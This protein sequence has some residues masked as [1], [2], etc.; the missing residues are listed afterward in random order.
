MKKPYERLI[1]YAKVNSMSSEEVPTS[2]TTE[3]QFALAN[4]LKDELIAMGVQDVVLGDSCVV[5]GKIPATAGQEEA[6]AI[7]F[8]AHL[9]TVP[10]F[11][12]EHVKPLVHENYDGTDIA[13]PNCGRVISVSDFPHLAQM[14]GKTIITA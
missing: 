13:L 4:I 11:P 3:I 6:P 5:Y 1:E 9:D 14:K 2:P 12:G 7:G 8:I 10:D